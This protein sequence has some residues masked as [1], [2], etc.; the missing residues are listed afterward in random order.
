[1]H[2]TAWRHRGNSEFEGPVDRGRL[3]PW[4]RTALHRDTQVQHIGNGEWRG[5]QGW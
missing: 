2:V 4:E 1:M 3:K 5:G